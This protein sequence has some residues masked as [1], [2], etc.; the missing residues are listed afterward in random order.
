QHW[1]RSEI[2]LS[3]ETGLKVEVEDR[4]KAYEEVKAVEEGRKMEEERRMN[5]NNSFGRRSK[6]LKN[7]KW[8]V[9]EQMRHVQEEH[10][11][12]MKNRSVYQKKDDKSG[13]G[14]LCILETV[15]IFIKRDGTVNIRRSSRENRSTRE[16]VRLKLRPQDNIY[17]DGKGLD[18]MCVCVTNL[19][20]STLVIEDDACAS[21]GGACRF[22]GSLKFYMSGAAIKTGDWKLRERKRN[23]HGGAR[24]WENER[25]AMP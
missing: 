6:R 12:S 5:R 4:L 16:R 3:S 17:R 10:E 7:E 8:L 20:G 18:V 22:A 13:I 9:E 2:N 24:T 25:L 19:S 15:E 21:V 14:K 11:T 23:Q 1:K